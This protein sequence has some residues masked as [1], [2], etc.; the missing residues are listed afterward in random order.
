MRTLF[1]HAYLLS[2]SSL[3]RVHIFI[4]LGYLPLRYFIWNGSMC[5]LGLLKAN[6]RILGDKVTDSHFQRGPTLG[7]SIALLNFL[8]GNI[9]NQHLLL[10]AFLKI[11]RCWLLNGLFL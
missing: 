6:L 9:Y 4:L 5:L 7:F 3:D 2:R 10:L 1:A 11:V 8:V